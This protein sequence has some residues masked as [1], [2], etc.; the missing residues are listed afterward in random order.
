MPQFSVVFDIPL[1]SSGCYLM[2]CHPVMFSGTHLKSE[3]HVWTQALICIFT[4][5]AYVHSMIHPSIHYY[6]LFLC[7]CMSLSFS[8]Y[9]AI[10]RSAMLSVIS[11]KNRLSDCSFWAKILTISALQLISSYWPLRHSRL[12]AMV[13]RDDTCEQ[14]ETK[15]SQLHSLLHQHHGVVTI[16][17]LAFIHGPH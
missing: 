12:W 8:S 15:Q 16:N 14:N 9:Q 11:N 5:K 13:G 10:R 6:Q 17:I 4:A 2:H 7:V 3:K 1:I